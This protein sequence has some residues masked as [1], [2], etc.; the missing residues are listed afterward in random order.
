[1]RIRRNDTFAYNSVIGLAWII[2]NDYFH[3]MLN[4]FQRL[5]VP[6]FLV[7]VSSTCLYLTYFVS[8]MAASKASFAETI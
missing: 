1:M 3:A 5:R 4:H 2:I 7:C 8:E 6:A